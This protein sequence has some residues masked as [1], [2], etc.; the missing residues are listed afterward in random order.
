MKREGRLTLFFLVLWQLSLG[1]IRESPVL[2]GKVRP[3]LMMR[4][5]YAED[6][7]F[8]PGCFYVRRVF[9]PVL[10]RGHAQER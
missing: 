2:E 4:G 3:C 10:L 5:I 6:L 8:F 9:V 1:Q 7:M